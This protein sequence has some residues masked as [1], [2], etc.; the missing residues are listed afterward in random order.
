MSVPITSIFK[1]LNSEECVGCQHLLS[2]VTDLKYVYF[3]PLKLKY[4]A[5]VFW[6]QNRPTK[7][8]DLQKSERFGK[9]YN[10]LNQMFFLLI[11]GRLKIL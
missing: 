10:L 3:L 7:S 5:S 11:V 2:V 9:K 4:P 6:C 8:E 1:E